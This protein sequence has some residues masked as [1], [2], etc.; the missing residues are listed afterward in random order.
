MSGKLAYF[1]TTIYYVK[2]NM[3]ILRGD[4]EVKEN[5]DRKVQGKEMG[6]RCELLP[7]GNRTFPLLGC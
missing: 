6:Y 5:T 3:R 1:R 2:K 4:L 7:R